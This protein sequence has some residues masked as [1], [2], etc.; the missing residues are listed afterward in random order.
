[1]STLD[2]LDRFHNRAVSRL[3]VKQGL[4]S[5][6]AVSILADRDASLWFATFGGLNRFDHG[7]IIVPSIAG[8][9]GRGKIDGN[10]PQSLF[11]DGRGRIW[12]TTF[13]GLGYLED[14]HF[15]SVEGV[16][17]GNFTSMTQ[18]T[19][20][21]LWAANTNSGLFR[22]SP[23]NDVMKTPWAD[24]GHEDPA[25]VLAADHTR[26]GIWIGFFRGG[27]AHFSDGQV[28][29]SYSAADGLGSGRVSDFLSDDEGVLWISTEGG[30]SRLQNNRLTTLTSR[31][32]LPCDTVHWAAE[33][34]DRSLWLYTACGLVRIARPR[35]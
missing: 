4:S 12:L 21:N 2:G 17:G 9:I 30:L 25:I 35:A 19:A 34:D 24:L 5:N 11:Q 7:Q 3:T 20:G 14:G 28:R 29:R 16:P 18:D 8:G 6:V 22:I 32:G 33:E 1:M 10:A 23:R 27:V 31:D 15:S 13:H 26:G